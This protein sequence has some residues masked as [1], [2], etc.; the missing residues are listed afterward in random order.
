MKIQF[1]PSFHTL[2]QYAH[3]VASVERSH[4][5]TSFLKQIRVNWNVD[6]ASIKVLFV[7]PPLE[8][9]RAEIRSLLDK[10]SDQTATDPD[11][12]ASFTDLADR[13]AGADDTDALLALLPL[14]DTLRMRAA[15]RQTNFATAS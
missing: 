10:I 7:A 2:A 3:F 15:G 4:S 1:T 6:P 13:A 12:S 5:F 11:L 9:A 8:D 14:I